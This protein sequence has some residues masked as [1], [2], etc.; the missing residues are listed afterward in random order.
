MTS[1]P[2]RPS[3]SH[4]DVLTK[5]IVVIGSP[6][7][8]TTIL[9]KILARH[10]DLVYLEE[11]RLTWRF[12][13]DKGSDMLRPQQAREAVI[14]HIR[15]S[16]AGKIR[17]AGGSRLLEKTPSN[18]L[19]M[20][21]VDRVLPDCRFIHIT[22]N[23]LDSVLSIRKFWEGHSGGIKPHKVK[24]RLK[25]INLRRLPH[26][27]KEMA[28]RAA[29]GWMS[30]MVG[31][32]VWGPRLPG[33]NGLARELGLLELCAMQWRTCVEAAVQYG[34]TLPSDRYLQYRLEDLSLE[35]LPEILEFCELQPDTAVEEFFQQ[36]FDPSLRGARKVDASEAE[37][38]EIMAWIEP[39]MRWLG[40]DSEV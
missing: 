6:R 27:A 2:D 4:A 28:R 23:G 8:G 24:Q 36:K 21:F 40:Y 14:A 3:L 22:R 30:G 18:A 19:R 13:N 9:G 11:P 26:Y 15:A 10:P 33:M 5:P 37:I 17:E 25:E 1:E 32:K 16:F 12:G 35:S 31:P 39:T 20:G 29:P 34:R 7:S 38:R